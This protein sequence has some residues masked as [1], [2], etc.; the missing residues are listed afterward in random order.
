MVVMGES[1]TAAC[2]APGAQHPMHEQ[3]F[4]SWLGDE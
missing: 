4:S 1:A 2:A 3:S